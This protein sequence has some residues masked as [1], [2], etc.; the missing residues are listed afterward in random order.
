MEF[1]KQNY[2]NTTTQIVV[3]SNTAS[4]QFLFSRDVRYQ[5]ASSGYTGSTATTI[6]INF[7]ETLTVSRIALLEH[8]FKDFSVYYNGVT[9]NV[10]ALTTT[11]AT[12]TA[13]FSSNSETS[14]YMYATPQACT[15]VS[16]QINNTI[17]GTSERAI[18]FLLLSDLT[19]EFERTPAAD[20]YKPSIDRKEIVHELSDGGIR[21]HVIQDKQAAEIKFKHVSESF[22]D[23]LKTVYDMATPQVFVPFGTTTAW[24]KII[25]EANWIGDFTFFQYSDDAVASGFSGVIKLRETS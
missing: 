6:T 24:D 8:N 2:V 14:M 10:F 4:S 1:V 18:G 3:D 12:T 13:N 20:N 9:A 25:F 19:L 5:Y 22:R 16:I 11:S 21:Q 23:D 17:S 15:S 7:S